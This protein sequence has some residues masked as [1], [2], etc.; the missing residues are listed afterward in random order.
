M[1]LLGNVSSPS[2]HCCQQRSS[3]SNSEWLPIRNPANLLQF[4]STILYLDPPLVLRL[5]NNLTLLLLL[6]IFI[7][8]FGVIDFFFKPLFDVLLQVLARSSLKEETVGELHLPKENH[9]MSSV[10]KTYRPS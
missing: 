3:V 7:D 10:W 2:Q 8:P 6:F 5:I 9:M 1:G 4:F